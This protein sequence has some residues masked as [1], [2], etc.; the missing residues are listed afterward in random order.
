[1]KHQVARRGEGHAR[2]SPAPSAV[3]R[4]VGVLPV[5]DQ[6]HALQARVH[7]GLGHDA[8]AQPVGE[9]LAG[10]AQRGPVLHQA[11]VVDVGHLGAADALVDPAHHVAEDALDV[12]VE[13]LAHLVR[14]ASCAERE[15][16]GE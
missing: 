8:V 10:D 2:R 12:V 5:D 3:G 14:P 13:L 15:R 7:L 4:I 6:R 11:D 16:R 9:Q 1:M